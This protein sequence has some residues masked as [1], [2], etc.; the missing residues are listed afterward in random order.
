MSASLDRIAATIGV[1]LDELTESRAAGYTYVPGAC[2]TCG[3]VY[4]DVHR[5]RA[6]RCDGCETATVY[7]W[8]VIADEDE[9]SMQAVRET[10]YRAPVTLAVVP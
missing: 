2:V 4:L 7:A 3:S 1:T 5:D 10:A 6:G 8:T 9:P